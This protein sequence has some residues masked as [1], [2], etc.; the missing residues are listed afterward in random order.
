MI[1]WR[2]YIESKFVIYIERKRERGRVIAWM[3]I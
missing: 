1:E 2:L 3:I